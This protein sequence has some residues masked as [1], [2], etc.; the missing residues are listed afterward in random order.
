M[1]YKQPKDEYPPIGII[2]SQPLK[3]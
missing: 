2:D 3:P 1:V